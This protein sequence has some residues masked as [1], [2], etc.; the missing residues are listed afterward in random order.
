M[1]KVGIDIGGTFTDCVIVDSR[2]RSTISKA[3]TTA[4]DPSVGVLDALSAG[5][6][7]LGVPVE[8][9]LSTC[10]AFFHSC[11]I[12]TNAIIERTGARTAF[13]TTKGQEDMLLI[14]KMSQKVAGLTE[15][16]IIHTS[17]LNRAEPPLVLRNLVFGVS[18][19]VIWNGEVL[20]PL[21]RK[22]VV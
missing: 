6:R 15:M 1:Y 16:E 10:D 17:R 18:E 2:G 5:C 13:V 21:D 11:T 3:S 4:R 19:R 8:K 14:G 9:L 12:G 7:T 22:S 20:V